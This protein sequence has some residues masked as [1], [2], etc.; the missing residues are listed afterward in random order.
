[1]TFSNKINTIKRRINITQY[2]KNNAKVIIFLIPYSNVINGGHLSFS[3]LINIFKNKKY[4][5]DCDVIASYLFL[6]NNINHT[7]FTEFNSNVFI[8]DLRTIFSHFNNFE[9]LTIHIPESYIH[10]LVNEIQT[11]SYPKY[12]I[13]K[14]NN[15][16][17]LT[18]NILNQNDEY[19]DDIKYLD[20]IKENITPNLTMT[21]AH[22]QYTSLEKR[23]KYD[24][25]IHHLS[26]WLNNE[27]Y[28]LKSFNEK[29]N[30][31]IISPDKFR[32]NSKL[33]KVEFI[34]YLKKELPD[35]KIIEIKNFTYE[36]YKNIIQKA[37]FAITFGEGLD[38]YFIETSLGEGSFQCV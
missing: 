5:H 20:W 33:T 8:Q 28:I 29:E 17:K 21:M 30:I 3:T 34:Q 26:A 16:K 2:S 31:I 14:I 36:E 15:A 23:T 4:I 10:F 32:E 22:K 25:P 27:P 18:I 12:I 24:M 7:H 11:P 35:F 38:G 6:N 19:M 9:E 37:K 13:E 1:M